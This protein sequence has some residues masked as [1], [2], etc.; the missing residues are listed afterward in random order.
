[1]GGKRCLEEPL[2]VWSLSGLGTNTYSFSQVQVAG[3]WS[4][5]RAWL[6]WDI[7]ALL[8]PAPQR[9]SSPGGD[10]LLWGCTGGTG[11]ALVQ[12]EAAADL[13][14]R[15]GFPSLGAASPDGGRSWDATGSHL[16]PQRRCP[17]ELGDSQR[18]WPRDA[19]EWLLSE[20]MEKTK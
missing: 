18:P 6:P 8:T 16:P 14:G 4:S 7:S 17:S 12:S 15:T 1:M 13:S 19:R 20:W 5:S 3:N 2:C 9:G 11:G 10:L